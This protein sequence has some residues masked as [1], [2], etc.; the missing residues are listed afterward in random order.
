MKFIKTSCAI[1]NNKNNYNV[2]YKQNFKSANLNPEIFS[3]RRLPDR[4]HFQIVK[5]KNDGLIRS[6]PIIKELN[7]PDL[8]KKSKFTYEKEL[9][10]LTKSYLKSLRPVLNRLNKNSKIL[11]IGCGNGF[12]LESLYN[13]DFKNVY[14]VEPSLD[15]VKKANSS[16]KKNISISMLKKGIYKPTSFDFIFL[17]QTLDHIPD[18]NNFLK[19]CNSYLKD[20]GY[21]LAFNHNV[22]SFSSFLLREKSPIIDIEHP[23]LYNFSTVKQILEKNRFILQK[24]YS[25][26]S[27]VSFKRLLELF[28][29]PL[30]FKKSILKSKNSLIQKLLAI[31]ISLKLGNL[32]AIAKKI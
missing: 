26:Y 32:C 4:I 20:G 1:C 23:Y 7:L 9:E 28:P 27:F 8:Y 16:I 21:I 15:A 24:V 13:L 10:N 5:C 31:S 14:G 2:L 3:A 29:L 19:I 11:E 18:P 22:N 6:N 25:P 30:T 17:F 12:I